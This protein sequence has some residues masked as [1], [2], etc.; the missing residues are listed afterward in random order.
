[1]KKILFLLL[2]LLLISC[3]ATSEEVTISSKPAMLTERALTFTPSKPIRTTK[4]PFNLLLISVPS[5]YK[6]EPTAWTLAA[7]NG[8]KIKVEAIFKTSDGIKTRFDH[9]GFM[10]GNQKQYLTLLADPNEKLKNEYV[11]LQIISSQPFLANEIKWL[12]TSKL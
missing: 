2:T 6:L 8:D 12:S 4:Y 1:M 3:S 9:V 10:T 5:T 11:E 7:P